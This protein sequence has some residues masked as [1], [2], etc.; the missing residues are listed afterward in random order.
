MKTEC[1]ELLAF[2]IICDITLD[3]SLNLRICLVYH[4][5]AVFHTYAYRDG[6]RW[7]APSTAITAYFDAVLIAAMQSASFH[8]GP[9]Q[10]GQE[11]CEI[12][13]A[14]GRVKECGRIINDRSL[15]VRSNSASR[16]DMTLQHALFVH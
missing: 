11:D 6:P 14:P 5:P 12:S 3:L 9:M 16:D 1:H 2:E 7:T 13:G 10:V 15:D 4:P 8:C